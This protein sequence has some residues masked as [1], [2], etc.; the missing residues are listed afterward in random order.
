MDEAIDW[1]KRHRQEL[2]VGTIVT[3]AGVTFIVI[4]AGAGVVVLAPLVLM[5]Q[6][7]STLD[8]VTCG[9]MK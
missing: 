3:A 6:S 9:E 8:A 5:T 1:L 7:G 2:L 4:S